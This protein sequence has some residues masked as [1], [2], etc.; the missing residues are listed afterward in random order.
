MNSDGIEVMRWVKSSKEQK[1]EIDE[2]QTCSK[3]NRF[4]EAM[5]ISFT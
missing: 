1:R 3:E 2:K 5:N 4:S